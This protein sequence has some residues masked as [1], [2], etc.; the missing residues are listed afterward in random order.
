MYL[1]YGKHY[2]AH[3]SSDTYDEMIFV[4]SIIIGVRVKLIDY[5]GHYL[6]LLEVETWRKT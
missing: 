5:L 3:S 2:I 6:L 1:S 4:L